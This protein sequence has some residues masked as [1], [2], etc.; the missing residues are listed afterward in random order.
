MTVVY[1]FVFGLAFGSFANA[2]VDRLAQGRPLHGRSCCDA[3]GRV[4]RPWE[5]VPVASYV[6]LR[7]RCGACGSAIGPRTPAVELASGFT[8]AALYAA[9]PLAIAAA[10]Y[11][12]LM[13]A[14]A[15][16]GVALKR[17]RRAHV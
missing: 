1:A 14:P 17:M 15:A 11:A 9:T 5:L 3:C 12:A 8:L 7:G 2:A 16:A 13:L 10:A 4:L 6:A